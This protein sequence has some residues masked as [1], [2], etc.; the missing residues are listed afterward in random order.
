MNKRQE[1]GTHGNLFMTCDVNSSMMLAESRPWSLSTR[2]NTPLRSFVN[3]SV[4]DFLTSET[5]LRY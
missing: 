4:A 3:L 1:G 5:E 2:S